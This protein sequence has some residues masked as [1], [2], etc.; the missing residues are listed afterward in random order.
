MR[1]RNDWWILALAGCSFASGTGFTFNVMGESPG[2]WPA[3]LSAVGLVDGPLSGA[4]VVVAPQGTKADPAAWVA[5]VE[6]GTILILE[7]DSPLAAAFGFKPGEKPHVM[8]RSVE[9]V[10]APKLKI[11]WEKPLELP[12]FEMP[13]E[14]RMFAK[15]RWLG[16]PLMAGLHR[17]SGAVLWV[18]ATPGPQGYER[19]PYI[20]QALADL[21]FEA[22]FRSQRL[23]AFFDSAYRSRVDLD[24]FAARWRAAG[25]SALHVAAWH[26]WE[27]DARVGSTICAN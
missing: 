7:G 22:P 6:N 20:M 15:E 14:A 3:I 17:G 21:G 5:R 18:A 11:V 19:F 10:H 8:A 24:Y 13:K 1:L 9:D 27:S 2:S 16:A 26:Y 12:I 4:G 25:I 23:W